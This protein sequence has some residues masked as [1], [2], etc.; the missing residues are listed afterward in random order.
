M[1]DNF[2]FD[3]RQLEKIHHFL[4]RRQETVSVAES[5]TSGLL[6]AALSQAEF[7][8][9]FYQGG[10]TTYNL[11]QKYKHLH[12]EPIHAEM[13]N[14]VSEKVTAEMAL[15]VC[16]LFNS[17]WGIAVT[18]YATPVP[19]SGNK[20]FAFYAIAHG[21]KIVAKGKLVPEKKKPLQLQ[22]QYVNSILKALAGKL[23]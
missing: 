3:I 21:V 8:S 1:I 17:E 16:R 19:E 18:G 9:E 10:I 12:V 22:L 15:N 2:V 6:Q 20:V 5:V 13:T 7:A 11:G 4:K 23:K 14:C